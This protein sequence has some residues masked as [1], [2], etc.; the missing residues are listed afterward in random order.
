V[1]S[2]IGPTPYERVAANACGG[3]CHNLCNRVARYTLGIGRGYASAGEDANAGSRCSIM[4]TVNSIE[5]F[6]NLE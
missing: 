5:R 1:I 2:A 4:W 6:K 3:Y